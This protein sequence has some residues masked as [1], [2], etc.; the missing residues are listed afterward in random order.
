MPP[1]KYIHK[2]V[3]TSN[4]LGPEGSSKYSRDKKGTYP[5]YISRIEIGLIWAKIRY[6]KS[7]SKA[8]SIGFQKD[9][10]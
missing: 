8:L 9:M 5:Y 6:I 1:S 3:K 7:H 2:I 4:I 10:K